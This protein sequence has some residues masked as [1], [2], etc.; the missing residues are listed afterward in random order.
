MTQIVLYVWTYICIARH[1]Q[2]SLSENDDEALPM[3]DIILPTGAMGNIVA[4]YMSQLMGLPIRTL[5]AAVNINDIMY[6]TI[7][8]G[9]FH[10]SPNPMERTLSEAINI[11]IPYNFERMMYYITNENDQLVKEYYE[12]LDSTQQINI[13]DEYLQKIQA[14]FR[15]ARV[16]DEQMC[17]AMR[18]VYDE[19][20]QYVVDPHTAVAFSAAYQLRY[21]QSSE[22]QDKRELASTD[23]D[24]NSATKNISKASTPTAAV[25]L[26]TASPCKFKHPVTVA[27][28]SDTWDSYVQSESYPNRA[29]RIL[30][31]RSSKAS[32]SDVHQYTND[33]NEPI[34][35]IQKEWEARSRQLILNLERE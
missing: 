19:Y 6:H 25:L 26:A 29:K 4:G 28:G 13:S 12:S 1:E 2:W 18:Q 31:L 17:A 15:S 21:I 35:E 9:T 23:V 27:L 16:T 24:N 33:K 14:I 5:V 7:N 30:S 22:S 34:A 3:I 11:Q 32:A 8:H 10:K 20:N